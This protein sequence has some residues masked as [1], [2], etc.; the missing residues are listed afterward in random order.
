MSDKVKST[1]GVQATN[2][3]KKKIG[4]I[5]IFSEKKKIHI[6]FEK[7]PLKHSNVFSCFYLTKMLEKCK[8]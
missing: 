4:L 8:H 1:I 3:S 7:I 5:F 2:V 6:Y